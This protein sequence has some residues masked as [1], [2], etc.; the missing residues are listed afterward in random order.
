MAFYSKKV[1]PQRQIICPFLKDN[2]TNVEVVSSRY[3]HWTLITTININPEEM[4]EDEARD[5]DLIIV[6]AFHL[7]VILDIQS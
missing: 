3:N 2:I 7:D 4:D 6:V 5:A 1:E